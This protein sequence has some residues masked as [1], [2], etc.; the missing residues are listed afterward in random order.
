MD[1]GKILL[2]NLAKGKIGEDT[3]ALLGSL[4]LARLGLAALSRADRPEAERRDFFLYLG[5][6]PQKGE[7]SH[8]I[9]KS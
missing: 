6:P 9:C 2:V 7:T 3:S 8:R 1:E 5:R 4:L